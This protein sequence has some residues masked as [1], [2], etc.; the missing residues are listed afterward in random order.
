MQKKADNDNLVKQGR[1]TIVDKGRSVNNGKTVGILF[2][3]KGDTCTPPH[4]I[5]YRGNS[6]QGNHRGTLWDDTPKKLQ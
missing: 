3:A 6:H 1:R 4:T 2:S 5:S